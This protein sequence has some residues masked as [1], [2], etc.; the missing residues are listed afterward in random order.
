MYSYK[1]I[2]NYFIGKS[3]EENIQITPMKL[4]KLI[5]FAHGW[6][7]ALTGN[8]LLKEEIEAW[9][10]GPVISKLYHDLKVYG[11]SPI[12]QPIIDFV[13]GKFVP[14]II[15]SEDIETLEILNKVWDV[16][17]PYDGVR[18][19][20]A[21]HVKGSPWNETCKN[22]SVVIDNDLIKGYFTQQ[23]AVNV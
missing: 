23:A 1:Q 2:A 12:T 4:Q 18:L 20:N 22:G 19:A 13:E 6:H 21:T 5:Y 11:D 8:P 9:K 15:P 17:K 7:L 16:Y 10:Y 3:L 14:P